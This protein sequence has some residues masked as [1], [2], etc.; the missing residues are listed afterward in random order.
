MDT[1]IGLQSTFDEALHAFKTFD[2]CR[3]KAEEDV[4]VFYGRWKS[5][6][7]L[8]E[9]YGCWM[10]DAALALKLLGACRLQQAEASKVLEITRS[11]RPD[12][13]M[14]VLCDV[15]N[16]VVESG[17]LKCLY[18]EMRFLGSGWS[19]RE[20][21][22]IHLG[23]IHLEEDL[24]RAVEERFGKE[25][26]WECFDCPGI[27]LDTSYSRGEH[28]LEAH[29]WVQLTHAEDQVFNNAKY[30]GGITLTKV[31][32][33][34]LLGESISKK[35]RRTDSEP[36]KENQKKTKYIESM[37]QSTHDCQLCH[38]NE[39]KKMNGTKML[40]HY[41]EC[42]FERG[43]FAK[44]ID[45]GQYNLDEKGFVKDVFGKIFRYKCLENSCPK[46]LFC[47]EKCRALK[48]RK[49]CNNSMGFK[50][51]CIHAATR[52]NTLQLVLSQAVL[53]EPGLVEVIQALESSSEEILPP[54]FT[55]E[56]LHTCLL[57]NGKEK[58]GDKI[59]LNK[60]DLK[61]LKYHYAT[62]FF[63]SGVYLNLYPPGK[64]NMDGSRV[65]DLFGQNITYNCHRCGQRKS[66]GYK[67][68]ALHMATE[69][70]G[71]DMIMLLD[72]RKEVRSFARRIGL[73]QGQSPLW[74][75][76]LRQLDQFRRRHEHLQRILEDVTEDEQP[77]SI[78]G[79]SQLL[80]EVAW[81][82]MNGGLELMVR[83]EELL[84][85]IDNL[86]E[87]HGQ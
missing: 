11:L 45:P 50:E 49:D 36:D 43:Y 68:F 58:D 65:K 57:C 59:L 12:L 83:K 38:H 5:A 41:S 9:Q 69:H 39:G 15:N 87:A 8:L 61:L 64:V 24:L 79:L 55:R 62:C 4:M 80:E 33:R 77:I 23:K 16:E 21:V 76:G 56:E 37:F 66:M 44:L 48:C 27:M 78:Q 60:R 84:T 18:C 35:R 73:G 14:T 53:D 2:Q 46:F 40:V 42:L 13:I 67:G 29:P 81:S 1:K 32:E 47:Q 86:I 7:Q 63:S 34:N 54:K 28:V 74:W 70:G 72:K 75:Q 82:D 30:S 19:A 26:K 20:S 51:F 31:N 10:N 17:G 52:H 6:Q 25:E 85:E 71:L 22:R 3:R